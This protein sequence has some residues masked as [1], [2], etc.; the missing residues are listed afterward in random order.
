MGEDTIQPSTG[1]TNLSA[2]RAQPLSPGL[3]P[4]PLH[5]GL[6]PSDTLLS[7]C[8]SEG[9]AGL[10]HEA[11]ILAHAYAHTHTQTS[12][13]ACTHVDTCTHRHMHT[14]RHVLRYTQAPDTRTCAHTETHIC[15]HTYTCTCAHTCTRRHTHTHAHTW[16]GLLT[17][18]PRTRGFLVRNSHLLRGPAGRQRY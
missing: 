8:P 9:A 16:V 18:R 15:R 1:V 17:E 12:A 5:S 4:G 3:D 14:C 7:H 6:P 11:D 13:H 10:S 2:A